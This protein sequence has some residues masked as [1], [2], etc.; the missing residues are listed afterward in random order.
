MTSHSNIKRPSCLTAL[1]STDDIHH[2]LRLSSQYPCFLTL[3]T[4][5]LTSSSTLSTSPVVHFCFYITVII[6]SSTTTI[7]TPPLSSCHQNHHHPIIHHANRTIISTPPH[8]QHF[9]RT[10]I[11]TSTESTIST[12]AS[13]HHQSHNLNA[14]EPPS[15]RHHAPQIYA[16]DAYRTAGMPCAAVYFWSGWELPA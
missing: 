7:S 11:S 12:T 2:L 13:L 15:P 9:T 6:A 10:T 4:P 3:A 8:Y 5:T 14:T 1:H 16:C